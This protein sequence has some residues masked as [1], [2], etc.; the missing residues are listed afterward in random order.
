MSSQESS[1]KKAL[2]QMRVVVVQLGRTSDVLQ[3]L[4]SLRAAKQLY[5]H[6]MFHMIVREKFSDAAKK[7][8]W[9]DGVTTLPIDLLFKG[10]DNSAASRKETLK[11]LS[12]LLIPLTQKPWDLVINW[13]FSEASSFLTALLPGFVKTGYS[14]RDDGCLSAIDGWSHFIQAVVQSELPQNIHTTDI[15]TTQLLTALQIHAGDPNPTAGESAVTSKTFFNLELG[16]REVFQN[17][18][19]V[20]RKWIGIQLSASCE[21][22]RY[23]AES[24]AH[25]SNQLLRRHPECGIVL[26]GSSKEDVLAREFFEHIG[27]GERTRVVSLVGNTDFDLWA[28]VIGRCHWLVACDSAAIHLASVLGTRVLELAIGGTRYEETGPYGNGHYVLQSALGEL[29]SPELIYGLWAYA[30]SEWSHRRNANLSHHLSELGLTH[31]IGNHRVFRSKIRNAQDGGGVVYEPLLKHAMT[32]D[33]WMSKVT[34]HLARAWYCGWV[35]AVGH[36][37]DRETLSPSLIQGLRKLND[38]S[39]VL[40]KIFQES[41]KT[42][43]ELSNKSAKLKSDKVMSLEYRDVLRELGKKLMELETLIERMGTSDPQLQV[44]NRLTK[45]LMHNL[46]GAHLSDLG[47]ETAENYKMLLQGLDLIRD[48]VKHTLKLIRPVA[49]VQNDVKLVGKIGIKES[50][51]L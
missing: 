37:L 14:R 6:L 21:E 4:M 38:T 49:V 28:S 36:E 1:E 33:D 47:R 29:P 16:E 8:A 12:A 35:P 22:R 13:T 5:P 25:F 30:S 15:L 19:D 17:L 26:L 32:T 34:G 3:S 39:E 42:A 45:V 44:F 27:T 50:E 20:S 40:A 9:L 46:P 18:K 48:W 24:L 43:Q 41:I 2:K 31:T 11:Q 23:S 51:P 10:F 7:V